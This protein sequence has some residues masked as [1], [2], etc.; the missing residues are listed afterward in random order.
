MFSEQYIRNN[1]LNI[2]DKEELLSDTPT[3]IINKNMSPLIEEDTIETAKLDKVDA[4]EDKSIADELI[5][6]DNNFSEYVLKSMASNLRFVSG[7]VM[8]PGTYPLADRVRL[9]DLI[10]VVGVI[11]TKAASAIVITKSVKEKNELI[12]STPEVLE[13]NSLIT[14]EIVL[15][16]EF[17]V[18]VP[19]AVNEAVN[20]FINLSGEFKVPGDYAFTRSEPLS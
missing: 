19:K 12:K 3:E 10:D 20:G 4:L 2:L 15:S 17:Y 16:G 11:E 7:A 1:F 5:D 8:F 6:L 18:D 13:L 14:N 9:K